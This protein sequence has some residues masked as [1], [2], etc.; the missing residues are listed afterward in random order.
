MAEDIDTISYAYD[1]SMSLKNRGIIWLT[2]HTHPF[3]PQSDPAVVDLS[4]GDIRWQLA[5][6]W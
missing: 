5:A 6:E 1:I 4:I 2:S 3:T